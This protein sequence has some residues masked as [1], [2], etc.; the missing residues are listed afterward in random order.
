[1]LAL[2]VFFCGGIM[3][4]THDLPYTCELARYVV[5]GG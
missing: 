3:R 2:K 1:M 5:G 4:T